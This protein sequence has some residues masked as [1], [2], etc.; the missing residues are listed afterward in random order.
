MYAA[1]V[2]GIICCL[3]PCN[4]WENGSQL[5]CKGDHSKTECDDTIVILDKDNLLMMNVRYDKA[6]FTNHF[7]ISDRLGS[8][9]QTYTTSVFSFFFKHMD[10][11]FKLRFQ[12]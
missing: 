8:L 5:M 12:N 1:L 4:Y 10:N 9:Q 7:S 2:H 6:F 11:F 3:E